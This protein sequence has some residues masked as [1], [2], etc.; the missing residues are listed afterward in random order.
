MQL[1]GL[2]VVSEEIQ[3]RRVS[4]S[5][6]IRGPRSSRVGVSPKVSLRGKHGPPLEIVLLKTPPLPSSLVEVAFENW[7]RVAFYVGSTVK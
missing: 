1:P 4:S 6:Q 2:T 5:A 3:A 7:K